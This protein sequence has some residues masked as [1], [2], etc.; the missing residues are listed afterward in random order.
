MFK[1]I[2]YKINKYFNEKSLIKYKEY[3]NV[4][5]NEN[6]YSVKLDAFDAQLNDKIFFT[7]KNTGTS[8]FLINAYYYL[9]NRTRC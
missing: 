8:K 9:L 4:T 5:T 2:K 1:W 6:I 3:N 7:I